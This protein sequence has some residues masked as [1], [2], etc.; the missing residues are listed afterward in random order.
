M[1]QQRQDHPGVVVTGRAV[2]MAEAVAHALRAAGF[3]ATTDPG[4]A[5][6]DAWVVALD[7]AHLPASHR[8]H[9]IL[10]SRDPGPDGTI[11]VDPVAG[12]ERLCQALRGQRPR[13]SA[14]QAHARGDQPPGLDVLSVRERQV[15][16]ALGA[17]QSNAQIAARLGISPH[18][19]RTHVSR[20]FA[21][22]GAANRL[23]AGA[24]ARRW[25]LD[26]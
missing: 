6:D 11:A 26:P 15:L 13:P 2:A 1:Q 3:E 18:T 4:V 7:D 5:A 24:L 22:V 10:I 19:V 25:G 9:R 12:L 16:A 20:V 8:G 23:E 17:G 21:K 14:P